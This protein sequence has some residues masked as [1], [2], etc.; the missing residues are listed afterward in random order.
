MSTSTRS[1]R[2]ASLRALAAERDV[3]LA[4]LEHVNDET[5]EISLLADRLGLH[6]LIVFDLEL[7]LE[8]MLETSDQ[9][10]TR[11]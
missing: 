8:E 11:R 9:L 6:R 2:I 10:T 3:N 1:E 7:S 4:G 5:Q